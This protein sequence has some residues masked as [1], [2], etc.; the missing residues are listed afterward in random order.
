MPW[1]RHIKT[2][3]D[4][5][6]D[7][8]RDGHRQV[9]D[10]DTN[11]DGHAQTQMRQKH[12]R[13]RQGHRVFL[14]GGCLLG[15]RGLLSMG[16]AFE[17]GRPFENGCLLERRMSPCERRWLFQRRMSLSQKHVCG[18]QNVSWPRGCLLTKDVFLTEDACFQAIPAWAHARLFA[19]AARAPV[20]AMNGRG[21][22]LRACRRFCAAPSN[23]AHAALLRLCALSRAGRAGPALTGTPSG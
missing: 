7:S 15:T 14:Q 9:S 22:G 4:G 8:D 23:A 20:S 5:D 2:D 13:M 16:C 18:Q 21:D 17:R 6:R 19:H 1:P 10:R 3:E 12:T 11:R